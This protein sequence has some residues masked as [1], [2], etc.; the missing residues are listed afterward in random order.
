METTKEIFKK[1]P[2]YDDYYVSNYGN[3]KSTKGVKERIRKPSL[4]GRG[5]LS[6]VLFKDGKIKQ[7]TIHKL[8]AMAF[9]GYVPDGT[10][11]E[12]VDHIDNNKLNN[13]LN[14]LRLVTN[15][16][17]LSRRK[18]GTS[19]YTGVYWNKP[20]KKWLAQI[21]I[22]GKRKHLGLFKDEHQAYLSYQKELKLITK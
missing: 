13:C 10:N 3:V 8:V 6:V 17:N 5:Y 11:K 7:M 4:V 12:V 14:N 22:N 9:L 20:T 16:F 15:R 19:K 2:D 18:G 1:I 21:Q